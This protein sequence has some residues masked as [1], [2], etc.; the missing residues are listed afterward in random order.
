MSEHAP[1]RIGVV[2]TGFVAKNFVTELLRRAPGQRLG[3]IL[4]RRPLDSVTG[5]PR[6][7]LTHDLDALIEHADL[8]FECS[9]DVAHTTR[10]VGRALE[11]GL[12]VATLNAEFHVTTGS[13][14]AGSGR[15][16]ECAGDQPGTL[17][18]LAESA[19]VMGFSPL[20]YG[21]MKGFLNRTP[22]P[23]DMAYWG[24]RQGY[25][26]PMVTSFTDGTKVQIEQCLVANGLGAGIAQEDLLGPADENLVSAGRL[27]AEAAEGLGHPISDYVLGRTHPH[28]VFIVA[29]HDPAQ[30]AALVNYKMGEG[31][32]YLLSTPHC[33]VHLE[34]FKTIDRLARGGTPLLTNGV[35]PTIGVAAVAKRVLEPGLHIARGA[36]GFDL[37]GICVRL[38]E[39]PGHLPICLADDVHVR[40]RIEPGEV[41]MLD[42]VDLPESE[43]LACWRRI[44][45]EALAGTTT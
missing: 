32:Y 40:R 38:A 5:L 22:S 33:L 3:K 13:A 43:A 2:G 20:V 10:V 29:R 25:S 34:A 12:P 4:T 26:L 27:L 16:S 31:P 30:A 45:A 7:A 41:L 18:D 23:E 24:E 21:N 28:G 11:A 19:L 17:A 1:I 15:L 44:E 14:F 8:V 37:R 42:D 6:D 36:G 39:R 35:R 9:G